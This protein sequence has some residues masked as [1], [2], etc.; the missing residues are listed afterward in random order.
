MAHTPCLRKTSTTYPLA[1]TIHPTSIKQPRSTPHARSKLQNTTQSNPNPLPPLSLQLQLQLQLPPITVT[2]AAPPTARV[3][4]KPYS[5]G[6]GGPPS[7][8]Q[9]FTR[10]ACVYGTKELGYRSGVAAGAG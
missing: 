1:N 7:D 9:T 3:N 5:Q 4:P 8:P 10:H 2:R 6:K